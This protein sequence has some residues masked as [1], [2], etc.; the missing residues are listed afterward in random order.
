MAWASSGVSVMTLP[1]PKLTPPLAAVPGW[2]RRLLAPMLAIDFW[3]AFDEPLPISI[4]AITAP[5]PM[6]M[7]RVVNAA[8]MGL[9][10]SARKAV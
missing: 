5:T 8:R 9:R 6:T 4:M 10:R 7:P 3:M 2:M 1:E